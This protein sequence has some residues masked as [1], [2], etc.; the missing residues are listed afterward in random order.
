[1]FDRLIEAYQ[2]QPVPLPATE[3][4][5]PD[6]D[7]IVRILCRVIVF[8][9]RTICSLLDRPFMRVVREIIVI[10]VESSRLLFAWSLATQA[11]I[12][13]YIVW[14][15]HGDACLPE[16][17]YFVM[18]DFVGNKIIYL[19]LG[20]YTFE[21]PLDVV[22]IA[23]TV[24]EN[25][26]FI[27]WEMLDDKDR[28]DADTF[29]AGGYSDWAFYCTGWLV[30]FHVIPRVYRSLRRYYIR[31]PGH[32]PV[33]VYAGA[34]DERTCIVCAE[35]L[36]PGERV[37]QLNPCGHVYH[38]PCAREWITHRQS[39]PLCRKPVVLRPTHVSI[40]ICLILAMYLP[41]IYISTP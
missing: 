19:L 36:V 29:H 32:L 33:T 1:M 5:A 22:D 35:D 9:L 41:L 8:I 40:R 4:P 3:E 17:T 2:R 16:S 37:I 10:Y 13:G 23:Y 34:C 7:W 14:F 6:M 11:V 15:E 24:R 26:E 21:M 30:L 27:R 12:L 20:W 31:V 18:T 39:C 25:V 38:A 28:S